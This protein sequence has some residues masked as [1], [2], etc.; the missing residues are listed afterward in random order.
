MVY[1]VADAGMAEVFT[2]A[3]NAPL[4]PI[5]AEVATLLI[6]IETLSVLGGNRL[7]AVM[8]PIKVIEAVPYVIC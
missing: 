1:A 4:A 8:L 2:V 3:E 7:P 6:V 5:V